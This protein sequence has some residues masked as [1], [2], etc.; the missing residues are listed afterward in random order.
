ML[1]LLGLAV[2]MYYT[3]LDLYLRLRMHFLLRSKVYQLSDGALKSELSNSLITFKQ[4]L[5]TEATSTH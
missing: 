2:F 4:L 5:L 1:P 3:A